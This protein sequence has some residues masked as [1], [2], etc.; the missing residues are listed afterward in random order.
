M[1]ARSNSV[2]S[3][4]PPIISLF[5]VGAFFLIILGLLFP[6]IF[7]SSADSILFGWILIVMS[8]VSFLPIFRQLILGKFNLFALPVWTTVE[9]WLRMG[10][11]SI[12]YY[13][14]PQGYNQLTQ[15]FSADGLKWFNLAAFYWTV[16]IPFL[17]IGYRSHLGQW[18]GR[19][20]P[21]HRIINYR[22][23]VGIR[24]P[25]VAGVYIILTCI[26]IY[27]VATKKYGMLI[28]LNENEQAQE[29]FQV[30]P[31]T[32]QYL[33]II[34]SMVAVVLLVHYVKFQKYKKI[35]LFFLIG[36]IFTEVGFRIV[37]GSK[38]LII[39]FFIALATSY[40]MMTGRVVRYLALGFLILFATI[41]L[42]LA[43]RQAINDN[44]VGGSAMNILSGIANLGGE[45]LGSSDRVTSSI[46]SGIYTAGE[47]SAQLQNF[48]A[49][50]KH[51]EEGREEH[52]YGKEWLKIP[53]MFVIP[54]FIWKNK[55][56]YK[57]NGK[58][59]MA[60]VYGKWKMK[61]YSIAVTIQGEYFIHFGVW[62]IMGGMFFL[63]VVHR[64]L[65]ERYWNVS[66]IYCLCVYQAIALAVGP[67]VIPSGSIAIIRL[68][69]LLHIM[70]KIMLIRS[71]ETN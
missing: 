15:I 64:I 58:W 9:Q 46:K 36:V 33:E 24:L 4:I 48:A 54:Y 59:M 51:F 16:S 61:T 2:N 55:P 53:V 71:P 38:G 35:I 66:D 70:G 31:F 52:N 30:F 34:G 37:W 20:R 22:P 17:W 42:N 39:Y 13:E 40:Y 18:L 1:V 68:L 26:R 47:Y 5:V 41:P 27:L 21:L 49:I 60:E 45:I 6:Y 23:A 44:R 67:G 11:L 63:G 25:A 32:A 3:K 65:M 10:F 12:Y 57:Y 8:V 56:V 29:E 14:N 43:Y 19:V 62:G 69:V 50:V 7:V 28:L